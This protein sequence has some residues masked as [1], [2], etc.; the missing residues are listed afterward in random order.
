M[1][2]FLRDSVTIINISNPTT[3]LFVKEILNNNGTLR[4]D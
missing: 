4:L 3:P 2:N 1:T